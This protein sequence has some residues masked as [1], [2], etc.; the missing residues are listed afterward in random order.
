MES[1]RRGS[2]R[3]RNNSENGSGDE[4]KGMTAMPKMKLPSPPE[5][6]MCKRALY[7]SDVPNNNNVEDNLAVK[8]IHELAQE[9]AGKS[10]WM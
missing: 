9:C 1:V 7:T 8:I 10:V 3:S 2:S 5:H 4:E 6:A